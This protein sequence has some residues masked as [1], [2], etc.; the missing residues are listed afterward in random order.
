M[1]LLSAF[2]LTVAQKATMMQKRDDG[3]FFSDIWPE[4]AAELTFKN[5][6]RRLVTCATGY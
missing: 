5:Q 3:S 1:K 4:A 2:S 6:L